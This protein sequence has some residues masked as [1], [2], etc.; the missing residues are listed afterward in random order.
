M[1]EATHHQR[2]AISDEQ[3]VWRSGPELR[4]VEA[5]GENAIRVR[6]ALGE[7]IRESDAALLPPG[8]ADPRL[9]IVQRFMRDNKPGLGIK[10]PV[11]FYDATNPEARRYIWEKVRDNYLSLG[12][13]MWWLDCDEPELQ[14]YEF[15]NAQYWAGNGEEVSILYPN[16]HAKAFHEGMKEEGES[17]V[18]L[19]SRAG[20]AG[21]QRYGTVLWSGDIPSTFDVLKRQVPA[22]LKVSMSGVP[23]WNTDIGGFFRGSLEEDRFR[24]LLI[25]WFQYGTFCPVMRLHGF[26]SP[27]EV[28]SFGEEAYEIL[29]RYLLIRE[30]MKPYLLDQMRAA[31]Q[32]G[33]PIMR[34]LFF[35]FPGDPDCE[36]VPDEYMFGP[37]LLVAPVTG[38]GTRSRPVYLPAGARWTDA[39]TGEELP[40]GQATEAQAP[41]DRIPLYLRDGAKLPI[42]EKSRDTKGPLDG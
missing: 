29:K 32:S 31:H 33:T 38:E 42:G 21:I 22:G 25:R 17:D 11:Y 41:L 28:W 4:W 15:E 36:D 18:V 27:N 1:S 16:L 23:W 34:P 7:P 6:S 14:H 10:T 39:W 9:G 8:E 3:L 2:L 12:I 19:L 35:D 37:G 26:R 5:W 13:R 24:E 40:G 20:W 30:R